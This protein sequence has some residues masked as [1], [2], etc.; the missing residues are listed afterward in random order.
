MK[1]R[2]KEEMDKLVREWERDFLNNKEDILRSSI[3]LEEFK[4][5]LNQQIQDVKS[6]EGRSR[7]L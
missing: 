2:S 7:E 1:P 3:S 6:K 4:R 5:R